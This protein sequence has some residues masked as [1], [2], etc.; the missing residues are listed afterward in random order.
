MQITVNHKAM[1]TEAHNVE[2][3]VAQL[4]LPAQGVAV[5]VG[6]KLVK[7]ADWADC[8]LAEGAE[9]TIIKAACGG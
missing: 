8:P 7:R 2:A 3:L 1:Q 9:V 4:Q 5:A 6:G